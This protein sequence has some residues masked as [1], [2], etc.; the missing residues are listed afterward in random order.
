MT[1]RKYFVLVATILAIGLTGC[2]R[3]ELNNETTSSEDQASAEA[4]WDDIAQQVT[5]TSSLESFDGSVLWNQC[6]SVTIDTID[7]NNIFPALPIYG[8]DTAK[9]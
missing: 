9:S 2:R 7:S 5:G 1:R 8:D 4:L 3:Q 6:A